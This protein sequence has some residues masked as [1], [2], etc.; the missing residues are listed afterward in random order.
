M[1]TETLV[2]RISMMQGRTVYSLLGEWFGWV[3]A[4]LSVFGIGLANRA[5]RRR[6]ERDRRQHGKERS[7]KRR[8][9]A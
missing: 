8:S 9:V 3:C 7:I 4:G 1:E 5:A 6:K 2:G